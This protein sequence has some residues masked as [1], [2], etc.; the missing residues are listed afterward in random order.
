MIVACAFVAREAPTPRARDVSSERPH[1]I[2]ARR[3]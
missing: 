3:G 1:D 2:D